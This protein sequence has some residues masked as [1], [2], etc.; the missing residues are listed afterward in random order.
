[1][2]EEESGFL[3]GATSGALTGAAV[4]GP[5]GAAAGGIIGGFIGMAQ[6][7]AASSARRTALK[8]AER[9]R[10][11]SIVRQLG[12]KEQADSIALAGL[13]TNSTPSSS[14]TVVSGTPA[15]QPAPGIIGS[16]LKSSSG[17]F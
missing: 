7:S 17:T 4:G 5:V 12:L 6:G 14:G 8:D 10:Q 9:A 3:T 15:N 11:R 13:R 2:N 16:N 1:M